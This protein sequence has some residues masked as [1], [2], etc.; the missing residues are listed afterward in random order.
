MSRLV[1]FR[2]ASGPEIGIGHAMRARAVA[3]EVRSL[4]GRPR[5]VLD[6][7]STALFLAASGFEADVE[8]EVSGWA[9][10]PA[11][12]AWLDGFGDWTP[13]A[14]VLRAAGTPIFLVENRTAA[15]DLADRIVYPALHHRPDAWD[16]AHAE[17]VLAGAEWIPLARDVVETA[18]APRRDVDVLVT[19]GGSDPLHTTERVLVALGGADLRVAVAIGPHMAARRAW[20]ERMAGGVSGTTVLPTGARLAAWMARSRVAVTA[21]GTTLCELAYLGTPA[22]VVANY[23]HDREAMAWYAEHGPHHPVGVSDELT[24]AALAALLRDGFARLA[25]RAVRPIPHLGEGARA[26]AR[27][28]LSD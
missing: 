24:D 25:D 12:G 14:R 17:R 2:A 22:L 18:P 7:A 16:L 19:F 3:E 10:D 9:E 28:L 21:L 6:D 11:A 26:L 20:I 27:L 8:G 13:R 15:R 5:F 4:G 1:L 23:V